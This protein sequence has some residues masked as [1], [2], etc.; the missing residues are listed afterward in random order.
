MTAE[1]LPRSSLR[2]STPKA[3]SAYETE[4][5]PV[6]NKIVLANR[7]S[8]PDAVLQMV[9]DLCGG[10]FNRIE[11]VVPQKDLAAHAAKYKTIA[12]LSI[13][14]LNALHPTIPQGVIL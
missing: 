13:D 2:R 4:I 1:G 6:A 8:G 11:D 3:L 9:E 10:K 14:Q 12:G 5:L 7:G